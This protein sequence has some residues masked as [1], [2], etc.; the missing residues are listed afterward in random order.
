[1]L[2]LTVVGRGEM[3]AGRLSGGRA[4]YTISVEEVVVGPS[5]AW[6]GSEW[7]CWFAAEVGASPRALDR[8][9]RRGG[10]GR[11]CGCRVG[12]VV[13]CLWAVRSTL[14][15]SSLLEVCQTELVDLGAKLVVILVGRNGRT[16]AR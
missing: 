6:S 16:A 11:S 8:E 9:N 1:M 15:R 13:W 7:T 10:G 4:G 5:S 12:K 2:T 14:R 3:G